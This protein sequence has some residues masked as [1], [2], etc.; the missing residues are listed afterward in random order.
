MPCGCQ[1]GV[2][3]CRPYPL[4]YECVG[5]KLRNEP[6]PNLGHVFPLPRQACQVLAKPAKNHEGLGVLG[7]ILASFARNPW[8]Q[9]LPFRPLAVRV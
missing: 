1:L 7:V 6:K 9:N 2:K 4:C 5:K 8:P 3:S